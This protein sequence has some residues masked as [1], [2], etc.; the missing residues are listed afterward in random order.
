MN[1]FKKNI[2][3]TI[4]D[5]I[6]GRHLVSITSTLNPKPAGCSTS[7]VSFLDINNNLYEF[8]FDGDFNRTEPIG[9]CIIE[10][11]LIYDCQTRINLTWNDSIIC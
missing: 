10:S 5:L 9:I 2:Y 4:T 8:D 1:N 3:R 11:S 7:T 6:V